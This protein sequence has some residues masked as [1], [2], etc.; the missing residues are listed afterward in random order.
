MPMSDRFDMTRVAGA[1]SVNRDMK[2]PAPV[3]TT[4][5]KPSPATTTVTQ[6]ALLFP[7]FHESNQKRINKTELFHFCVDF[8][9][10]EFQ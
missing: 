6:F 10:K 9:S 7:S 2:T 8:V 4:T 5:S 1:I 3:M